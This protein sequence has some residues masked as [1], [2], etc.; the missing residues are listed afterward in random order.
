MFFLFQARSNSTAKPKDISRGSKRNASRIGRWSRQ[1]M[2][3]FES[4]EQRQ[5]LSG[6]PLI[7]TTLADTTNI[8]SGEV[9]SQYASGDTLS[10]RD[11]IAIA[12]N[13][14]VADAQL[15]TPIAAG[16]FDVSFSANI[17]ANDLPGQVSLSQQV[18]TPFGPTA[19]VVDSQIVIQGP[20]AANGGITIDTSDAMRLFQVNIDGVSNSNVPGGTYYLVGNLTLDD[21]TLSGGQAGGATGQGGAG[22]AGGGGG[23]GGLGGAI[24]NEGSL[25][26]LDSTLS[27]N[28]ATGGVGGQGGTGTVGGAGGGPLG[29]AGA[30]SNG[31]AHPGGL[32]SGGGGDSTIP[33]TGANYF[34]S[35]GIGGFGAGGGGAGQ[36]SAVHHWGYAA[37]DAGFGAVP[38]AVRT[39]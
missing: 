19:L 33:P 34:N 7:V 16:E 36:F 15:P 24:F 39:G 5:L 18:T 27:G 14:A 23:A 25:T 3:Q 2:T 29:G 31:I 12:N 30:G 11:A 13:T 6:N 9:Y 21:V 22:Y 8:S 1:R 32:G 35:T 28:T 26:L 20:L 38:A 17:V 4:L 37:Y 10:L